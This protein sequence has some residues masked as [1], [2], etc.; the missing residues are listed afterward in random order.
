MPE[1]TKDN[2]ILELY[3]LAKIMGVLE[4]DTVTVKVNGKDVPVNVVAYTIL[5]GA[6]KKGLLKFDELHMHFQS[7]PYGQY[8]EQFLKF[9]SNKTNLEELL[10]YN[11]EHQGFITRVY[12]W[13]KDR[14]NLELNNSGLND[15]ITEEER[16][17]IRTY[18]ETESG[19]DKIK[20]SS[21]TV[22][23]FIEEFKT[24]RFSG[25][26]DERSQELAKYLSGFEL[27]EQK[28]FDKS[29]EIDKERIDSRVNDHLVSQHIKEDVIDSL[30]D[31]KRRTQELKSHAI[32]NLSE[33]A[34]NQTDTASKIFTYE[35]LAKSNKANFAMGFLTS[36]CATLY[37]AGAGAQRAMILH[38]D[39][40]PLVIRN[41]QGEIIAFG[42]IYVN[43]K[44]GYAVINDFEVNRKYSDEETRKE[45]YTKAMQGVEKFVS[46]YNDE[47]KNNPIKIVTCGLSPNWNAV[48]DYIKANPKSEILKAPNFDDFK[49][50]GSGSWRGDWHTSQHIIWQEGK[51]ENRK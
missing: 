46:V 40:Q 20:W 19:I 2:N 27:Y 29:L 39:M 34:K 42:I 26:G 36:C 12:S 41:I 22:E 49:Y 37:G 7:L 48:N 5:Q 43:R 33:T 8:N 4:P 16:Y 30:E 24:N 28:H 47:N 17:K 51:K 38:P 32:E 50:N 11:R 9:M 3:K 15:P 25:F 10:S 35:M 31:Y 18:K 1:E 14:K 45:I 6:I 13:Y 23:L 21:P 44:E